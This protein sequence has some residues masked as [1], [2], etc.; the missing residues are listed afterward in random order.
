MGHILWGYIPGYI[1]EFIPGYI[2]EYIPGYVPE[3]IPGY[4]REN[5]PGYVPEYDLNNQVWYPGTPECTWYA[6][7]LINTTPS[8]YDVLTT[9]RKSNKTTRG[10]KIGADQQPF[11]K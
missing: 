2:R 3:F 1:P 6:L 4:I 8:T 11:G 9:L 10:E 5:I 7:L